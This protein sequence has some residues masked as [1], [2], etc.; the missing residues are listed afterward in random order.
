MGHRQI[1]CKQK[2]SCVFTNSEKKL[3]L[4]MPW[5]GY[6]YRQDMRNGGIPRKGKLLSQHMKEELKESFAGRGNA[7][8]KSIRQEKAWQTR[9]MRDIQYARGLVQGER[10]RS[11]QETKIQLIC[12][13]I[14]SF[15]TYLLLLCVRHC[16]EPEDKVFPRR[17]TPHHSNK[18][19]DN[20]LKN[21]NLKT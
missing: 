4:Y 15:I 17:L 19:S 14:H 13:F 9:K 2:S 18:K 5:I 3:M 7:S 21:E 16:S 8:S 10:L 12:S 6:N 11:G 20:F 1:C